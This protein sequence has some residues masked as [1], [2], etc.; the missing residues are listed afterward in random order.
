MGGSYHR[1]FGRK[2]ENCTL[3]IR[4]SQLPK[5]KFCPWKKNFRRH[6]NKYYSSAKEIIK[7][8]HCRKIERTGRKTGQ[9]NRN[10]RLCPDRRFYEYLYRS[11]TR[12][13]SKYF[14][15][16]DSFDGAL[17]SGFG[18][19]ARRFSRENYWKKLLK[20]ATDINMKNSPLSYIE[21]SKRKFNSQL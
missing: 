7:Q 9:E 8:K 16:A 5:A 12:H 11:L 15:G 2:T 21:L 19:R 18:G 17:S 1:N 13:R 20:M 4:A 14:A 3:L 10:Q 6:G